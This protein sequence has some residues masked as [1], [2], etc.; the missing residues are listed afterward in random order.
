MNNCQAT[1]FG[2]GTTLFFCSERTAI[3]V[4]FRFPGA[5]VSRSLQTIS[6]AMQTNGSAFNFGRFVPD[7]DA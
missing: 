5:G 7:G 2:R 6:K 4:D 1:A 3:V